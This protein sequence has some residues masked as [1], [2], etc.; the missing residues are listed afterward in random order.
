M[1]D[2]QKVSGIAQQKV[3]YP[4]RGGVVKASGAHKVR[5]AFRDPAA[6][7]E[8]GLL[9]TP[10]TVCRLRSRVTRTAETESVVRL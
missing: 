9:A 3:R 8:I 2:S 6:T 10:S 7:R 1:M 4:R 5:R